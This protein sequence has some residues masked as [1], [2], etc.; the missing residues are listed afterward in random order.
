MKN[1]LLI[2]EL[3]PLPSKENKS[4]SVCHF[5]TREWVKMGYNVVAIHFQPVHCWLWHL[6]VRFFGDYLKN[7][8]GGIYYERKIKDTEQYVMD[9]VQVFRIPIYNPIP[10]GRYK[11]QALNNFISKVYSA[12]DKAHFIPDVITGHMLPIE[13]IPAINVRY[14]AKTCMVSHGVSGKIKKRY[15]NYQELIDSY[16]I[17][18]FRAKPIKERFVRFFGEPKRTFYCL[19]GIPTDF[20]AEINPHDYNKALTS[21][22]Y[23]G[24]LIERKHPDALLKAIPQACDNHFSITY[25]GEGPEQT[26]LD[27]IIKADNLEDKIA[28]T[29]KIKRTDIYAYFDKSDCMIMISHGEAYG[30]VYL[31]AMA[32][33]CITIA[34]RNE[35]FDGIIIDGENGFLCEAGDSQELASIIKRI[36]NMSA[37]EKQRI[38]DKALQTAKEL[39]DE[40]AAKAYATELEKK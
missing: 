30:L 18:G 4:T 22:V 28:F 5:F 23:V 24:D 14:H 2:S 1:I 16:D 12:L 40:L 13:V 8:L 10:H 33:G 32:R 20:I 37:V 15:T 25:I 34:S 19:S 26:K 17:W 7:R 9:G 11:I 39:T 3:Y 29:G 21:F 27:T 38:S 6:A 31:E 35:G 36:N